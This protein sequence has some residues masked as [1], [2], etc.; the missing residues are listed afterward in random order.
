MSMQQLSKWAPSRCKFVKVDKQKDI[1][2]ERQLGLGGGLCEMWQTQTRHWRQQTPT[3]VRREGRAPPGCGLTSGITPGSGSLIVWR[4]FF[5]IFFYRN[6]GR[7]DYSGALQLKGIHTPNKPQLSGHLV[8]FQPAECIPFL[9]M[10]SHLL[11]LLSVFSCLNLFLQEDKDRGCRGQSLASGCLRPCHPDHR[12]QIELTVGTM[13]DGE[14]RTVVCQTWLL[15]V[16]SL[17][18]L[19]VFLRRPLSFLSLSFSVY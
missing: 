6:K 11:L 3:Y 17:P 12:W 5:F 4:F 7:G 10:H 8:W 14:W 19:P 2:R 1:S 13:Q 18:S 15:G 9:Q 16:V